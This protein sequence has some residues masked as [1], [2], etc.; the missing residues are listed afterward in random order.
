MDRVIHL[1]RYV[2]NKSAEV[3]EVGVNQLNDRYHRRLIH[4][5]IHV[6]KSMA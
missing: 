6:R 4:D 3:P 2:S 5:W 1:L